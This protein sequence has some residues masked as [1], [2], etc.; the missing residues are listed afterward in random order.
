MFTD[1]IP[2]ISVMIK[3][4]FR[5]CLLGGASGLQLTMSAGT[6]SLYMKKGP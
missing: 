3:K 4:F 2:Y 6:V 5:S 1:P